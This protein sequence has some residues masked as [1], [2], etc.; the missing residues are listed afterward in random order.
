MPPKLEGSIERARGD[1][2]TVRGP[3]DAED[4][5]RVARE[6]A[7]HGACA[8][9]PEFHGGV[10][11]ARDEHPAVGRP[12]ELVDGGHVGAERSDELAGVAVPQLHALVEGPARDEPPVRRERD[13]HHLLLVPCHPR[14][15][16][17]REP[18]G[19]ENECPII[20]SIIKNNL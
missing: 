16:L 15:R 20:G 10:L 6:V 5:V 18:G 7:R 9:V 17:C 11:G 2:L 4:L 3:V 19:P 12:R 14:N 13:R 8:D 1:K